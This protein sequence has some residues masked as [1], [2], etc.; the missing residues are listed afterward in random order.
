MRAL[1][2]FRSGMFAALLL[3]G[4]LMYNALTVSDLQHNNNLNIR[5]FEPLVNVFESLH[6]VVCVAV[7]ILMCHASQHSYI[8]HTHI[9]IYA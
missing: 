7:C 5:H 8:N 2:T 9:A 3:A 1:I 4:A 6:C